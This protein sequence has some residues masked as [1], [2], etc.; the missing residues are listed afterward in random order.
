MVLDANTLDYLVKL[1][2]LVGIPVGI[3]LYVINKRRERFEREYGTYNALDEKYID[4]LT[5]C[6]NHP[7]LDVADTPRREVKELDTEQ[8]HR[9]LVMFSILI[10]IMERAFLMY[11]DKSSAVRKVQWKGWDSYI[12]DW[13]G[14]KNFAVALPL[15][16]QQF[17]EDFCAY[18]DE[19][20]ASVGATTS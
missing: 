2:Q 11:S 13:C 8:Q 18:L 17:D 5:L 9:E 1:A 3:A 14:R 19:I 16:K 4:Y 12:R 7:D 20:V 10:A 6:M 15:L